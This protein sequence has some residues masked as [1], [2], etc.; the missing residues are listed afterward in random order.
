MLRA[1]AV[2][3]LAIVAGVGLLVVETLL[4]LR[5]PQVAFVP[6]SPAPT[7]LGSGPRLEYVVLGDSTAAGQGAAYDRGIAMATARHLARTH[8]VTLTNLAVSGAR[9]SDVEASQLPAA[10]R[11]RPD[12]VLIS[13]G[14]NDVTHLTR[15]DTV[16]QSLEA[17]VQSLRA[18]NPEVDIVVTAAPDMGSVPRLAQPL[19]AVA[20]WRTGQL[21]G[22]IE[23]VVERRE[24]VL[25]P[26]ASRTG[27]AFRRDAQ[28]FAEDRF[29]PNAEGYATWIPVL[30]DALD[31]AVSTR[32]GDHWG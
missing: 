2:I 32:A 7:T 28:L 11:R 16:T 27:P 22:A 6:P 5:G 12:V 29:H 17:V 8:R 4:A 24:L 1:A 19:R 21:N 18:A 25:A 20:G 23:D 13:A 3:V 9:M 30:T 15:A 14:A 10:A 31:R 26:I